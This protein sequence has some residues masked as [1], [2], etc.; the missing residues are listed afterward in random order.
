MYNS[1]SGVSTILWTVYLGVFN[2]DRFC[3]AEF[4]SASILLFLRCWNKF[5]M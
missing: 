4:I 1:E 5:S 2:I 3:H